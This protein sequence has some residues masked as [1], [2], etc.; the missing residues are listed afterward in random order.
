MESVIEEQIKDMTSK[1]EVLDQR[2][3]EG[4]PMGSGWQIIKIDKL[5]IDT[6]RLNHC[7]GPHALKPLKNDLTQRAV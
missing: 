4:K 1:I 6:S 2:D 3:G 7:V 5:A